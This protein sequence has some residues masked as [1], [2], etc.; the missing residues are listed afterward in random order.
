MK[1]IHAPESPM[2]EPYKTYVAQRAEN[3]AAVLGS[4]RALQTEQDMQLC[5]RAIT[6][7]EVLV[8]GDVYG[9][10]VGDTNA[11]YKSVLYKSNNSGI[12]THSAEDALRYVEASLHMGNRVRM[13][14]PRESDGM[15]Q[16]VV[17]TCEQAEA[18][19]EAFDAL[20]T[21]GIVLMPHI[22]RITD[23]LSFGRIN[24][25]GAG[26]FQYVG[27]EEVLRRNGGELFAGADI[28]LSRGDSLHVE[29]A[30]R[31]LHIEPRALEVAERAIA[32]FKTHAIRSGRVSVDVL[33]GY[34]DS[35]KK[36]TAAVDVTPRVG[37]NTPA[38]VLAI[39][40]LMAYRSGIA[41][42][43]G[44]LVYDPRSASRPE[45]ATTFVDTDTLLIHARVQSLE[46]CDRDAD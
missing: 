6:P 28:A 32:R 18:V 4:I 7:D 46:E 23:R 39:S 37:G 42:A 30:M 44:R 1:I 13:K 41:Y 16:S 40:A 14:D 22:A 33:S 9:C 11:G 24:L 43:S 5:S 34:T 27:R 29:R 45:D 12:A 17:E 3:I 25:E 2:P 35:G 31:Q 36:I 10:V 21:T 20:S 8:D 19:L 26:S 15:G 38:E